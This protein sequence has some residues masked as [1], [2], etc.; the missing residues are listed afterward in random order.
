MSEKGCRE[1]GFD[2]RI[3]IALQDMLHFLE[4]L[5]NVGYCNCHRD[6]Q[7]TD[8]RLRNVAGLLDA[9][10]RLAN[11]NYYCPLMR[12]FAVEAVAE[13]AACLRFHCP[14]ISRCLAETGSL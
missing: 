8:D 9:A 4:G 6:R 13:N 5:T 11:C 2:P 10:E 1:K 3:R 12:K 14:A 7:K